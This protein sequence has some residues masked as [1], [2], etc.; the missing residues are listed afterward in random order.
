MYN[1]GTKV[2]LILAFKIIK[3]EI[4]LSPSDFFFRD[5][6]ANLQNN[7]R[8]VVSPLWRG[9]GNIHGFILNGKSYRQ[10]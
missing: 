5:E 7:V 9:P 6:R 4:G 1:D 2:D 3:E 10:G 8:M